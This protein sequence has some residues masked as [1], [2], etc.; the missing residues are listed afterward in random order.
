MKKTPE[1]TVSVPVGGNLAK[2]LEDGRALTWKEKDLRRLVHNAI[3]DLS[4]ETVAEELL[5][6]KVKH[7]PTLT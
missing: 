2:Q 6:E 5:F 1:K 4:M 7:Y 3:C